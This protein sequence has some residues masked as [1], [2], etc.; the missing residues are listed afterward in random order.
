MEEGLYQLCLE[1][2]MLMYEKGHDVGY[3]KGYDVGYDDCEN[4]NY[5][6]TGRFGPDYG[7]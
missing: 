6:H 4:L 1:V 5:F 2:G 3:E 7:Y